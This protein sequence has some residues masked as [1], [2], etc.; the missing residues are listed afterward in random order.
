MS[1]EK[2]KKLRDDMYQRHKNRPICGSL[3]IDK[4][5]DESQN[6]DKIGTKCPSS[7]KSQKVMTSA[8]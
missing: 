2:L 7:A 3:Y 5:L 4:E 8:Q 6:K 1:T